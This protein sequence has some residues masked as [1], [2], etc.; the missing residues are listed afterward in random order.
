MPDWDDHRGVKV[1]HITT[2]E[3]G[4]NLKDDLLLLANGAPHASSSNPTVDDD[5]TYDYAAGALW[6]NTSNRTLWVCTDATDGAAKWRSLFRRVDNALVLAPVAMVGSG[7]DSR[8]VQI[9]DSVGPRGSSAVDLQ[10]TR[11]ADSQVAAGARAAIIGGENNTAFS[12]DSVVAGGKGNNAGGGSGT[13]S[14]ISHT[15]SPTTTITTSA[16][17][18]LVSGQLVT[19]S[20]TTTTPSNALNTDL[21]VTVTGAT[22]FTVPVSVTVASASGNWT[23]STTAAYAFVAAGE[24]NKAVG[25]WSHAEGHS[26][27]ASSYGAHV[28]GSYNSASGPFSHAEGQLNTASGYTAHAEGNG[29]VADGSQAHAEGLYNHSGGYAAHAEGFFNWANADRSHVEGADNYAFAISS[30]VEGYS[31]SAYG[32]CSHVEGS[33]ST[34]VGNYAH[35]GGLQS[36]A[37]LN[38]QWA[39][40]SGGHS[41][42]PGSAQTT[43]TQL[44][45]TTSDSTTA[46]ELTLGGVSP[47]GTTGRLI[48][49]NNQTLSCLINIVGRKVG[50]GSGNQGSFI[51]QA[52]ICNTSGTTA[53]VGSVQTIGTDINPDNW[54]PSG[55]PYDPITITAD[56]TNDFL[57]ISVKGKASTNIRWMA[58]VI[59]SEVADGAIS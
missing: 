14:N 9:D 23:T 37:L 54:G 38:T 6:W 41:A 55:P 5:S 16:S 24:N 10:R 27:T 7:T 43:I 20:G 28:E 19:I 18:G 58:T 39:R 51:R 12:T 13:I 31:N 4:T 3:A 57:S 32:N 45:R 17:H 33:G 29:N 15:G 48:I 2:G 40:A 42:A 22:T 36:K 8:A 44:L 50:A 1:P 56:N 49:R 25:K 46:T 34:A 21:N 59:S 52:C 30:H 35:A 47:S 53:L 11:S 26:N